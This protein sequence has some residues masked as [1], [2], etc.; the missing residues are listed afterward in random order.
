M[1]ALALVFVPY[2]GLSSLQSVHIRHLPIPRRFRRFFE[3]AIEQA[4]RNT[5][6]RE[7][8]A[9]ATW[10]DAVIVSA[11][12]AAIIA[13][14]AFMVAIA[15]AVAERWSVHQAVIGFILLATL[16]S[17]SNVAAAI[18]L[19]IEGR[20]VAVVSEALNSNTLNII[21]G[22]CL[23]ALVFGLARPS[24]SIMI[25]TVWLLGM[26]VVA[27]VAAGSHKG[28]HRLGGTLLIL[29]YAVYVAIILGF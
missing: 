6:K 13:A 8:L 22:L 12:V 14:S 21:F 2:V 9:A 3:D 28:L 15:V 7:R 24:A 18:R 1:L 26:S 25:S 20:G 29:I 5:R 17:I 11:C 16:T 4:H 27:I 19:A 23:P 10:K